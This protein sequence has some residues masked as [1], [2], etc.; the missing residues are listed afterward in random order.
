M[1]K[2]SELYH[3][4]FL[5]YKFVRD[6]STA[7]HDTII[8]LHKKGTTSYENVRETDTLWRT[9]GSIDLIPREFA[10]FNEPM[11]NVIQIF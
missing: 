11:T 4:S 5:N 8:T 10:Y 6:Y 3:N 7:G 1:K 2:E 9:V